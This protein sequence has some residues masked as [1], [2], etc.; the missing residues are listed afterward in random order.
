MKKILNLFVIAI[1]TFISVIFIDAKAASYSFD[2]NDCTITGTTETCKLK[3]IVE[4]GT[5]TINELDLTVYFTN[6]TYS[7][8][9]PA[10]GWLV[11]KN[12]PNATNAANRDMILY[13]SKTSYGVGEYT[14]GTITATNALYGC[15][16]SVVPNFVRNTCKKVTIGETTLYYGLDG[17]ATTEYQY[18]T[19]CENL[20]CKALIDDNGS[21]VYYDKDGN[22]VDERVYNEQCLGKIYCKPDETTGKYYDNNGNEITYLQFEKLCR[23]HSCEILTDGNTTIYFGSNGNEVSEEEYYNDPSCHTPCDIVNGIYYDKNGRKT[24]KLEYTKQCLKNSCIEL[25]DGTY[26]DKDGNQTTKEEYLKQCFSCVKTGDKYYDTDGKEITAEEYDIKC[27]T[28]K[29]E[30]INDTYFNNEGKI[31]DEE[32]Y[33]LACN[34][35]KCEKVNNTYFDYNG[36]IV[37]E[38]EYNKS[39]GIDNPDTG[40]VLPIFYFIIGIGIA[41]IAFY[42]SKKYK[43][44]HN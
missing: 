20:S 34:T 31:V 32:T 37:N 15:Y 39:C 7:S 12:V 44:I 17:K 42:I 14:L 16:I 3:L 43:K 26:Y 40:N 33:D 30:K 10:N 35:H 9:Y 27:N 11:Q 19:Q 2:P 8:F 6:I 18:T 13:T 41:S 28:H 24:T 22:I 25:E 21:K 1:I 4:E 5:L 23:K 36:K 38:E 29:C